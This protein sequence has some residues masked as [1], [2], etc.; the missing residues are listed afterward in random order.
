MG[1]TREDH[2]LRH[3]PFRWLVTGTTINLKAGT[4]RE[5]VIT[6]RA[7]TAAAPI[8]IKGPVEGRDKAVL[9]GLGGRVFSIDHSY[10]TLDGFT[11][12]GQQNIARSEYVGKTL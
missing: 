4:Y 12:D 3:A 7:S 6:K 9:Y 11:I 1:K 2:P 5:A 10:Y 8:K